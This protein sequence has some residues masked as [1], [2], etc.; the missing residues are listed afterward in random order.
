MILRKR[1]ESGAGWGYAV[2]RWPILVLV[3]LWVVFL[4]V[5]YALI[6]FFI[7]FQ[8]YAL[9][10][11]GKRKGL[12]DVLRHVET[13]EEWVEAAKRLDDHLK[14]T[15][16]KKDPRFA[17]Y[18][19]HGVAMLIQHLRELREQKKDEELAMVLQG[20][21][22]YNFAGTQ[23]PMLYSQMYYGTKN[24]VV[25][26]IDELRTSI[27]YLDNTTGIS[28]QLKD[29]SFQLF[30][31]NFGEPALCL[32]GGATFSYRH[33]GVIK[34]LLDRGL[35]PNIISGT[36][37]GGL[38]AAM[39]C[40]RTNDELKQLLVPELADKITACWEPFP[41]WVRRWYQTGARFDSLDWA[42]RSCWFTMGSM[43]F[44]EAYERTGKILNISAV[45]ADPHSPAILCNYITCPD[46]IIWSSLLAS[47][48]VPGI[49]NPVVLM[50]K[51]KDGSIKP[52]SFG[53]K[54][55]DG[56]LRTDI[57]IQ[58][59]NTYFNVN[60]TI[61][62]QVNPHISLF[63][64]GPRGAVG[65]PVSHRKGRGWRGGFVGSAVENMV[66]LEIQKWLKLLKDLN[67][68]PRIMGQDWSNI[69]LQQFKGTV[70]L[71]PKIKL[72]DFWYILAD[73]DRE[74]LAAIILAGERSTFP[75][76]LFVE[77]YFKIYTSIQRTGKKI[78][79][80]MG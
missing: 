59:L 66:K 44:K 14:L 70:T 35:L 74:K 13:Y 28:E 39:A 49:L 8:E 5:V 67:L 33:F 71:F 56:S 11:R 50:T 63:M 27:E 6:R 24:L 46:A 54:W 34:A 40:T 47:A 68:L 19:Y 4:T 2:L 77:H 76:I 17:F 12:R 30:K 18:D 69:W 65:R 79:L 41:F 1:E 55:K 38:V 73:P 9:T 26:Y 51:N 29:M 52:F 75:K 16:W 31:R 64:Y 57:P 62:S 61:V 48:A 37:G 25:D 21:V 78:G 45:P 7:A 15:D 80:N 53:S 72:S 22:K 32:S 10:W 3:S 23:G 60:F 20:C 58:A 36:S 43:T 42:R